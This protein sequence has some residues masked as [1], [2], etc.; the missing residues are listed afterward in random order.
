MAVNPLFT[1]I[2]PTA[3]RADL[4]R[5]AI[6][7]VMKQHC[8]DWEICIVDDGSTDHT[9]EVVKNFTDP[10]IHYSYQQHQER[11]V[12]RN[13]GIEMAKGQ[14]LCFLDDD[15]YF[16]PEHLELLR[17]SIQKEAYPV[18]IFRT[19]ML[20]EREGQFS[21]TPNFNPAQSPNP[22]LFFLKN[23]AGI[24]TLCFHQKIIQTYSFDPRWF[25]FQDTHLLIR[26]L[27][28]FP[29][30]QLDTYTCVYVRYENMGSISVF[31]SEKAEARTAN[32]VSAIRD[33]FQQGGQE[34]QTLVPP[35]LEDYLV[36]QKYLDHAKGALH[37]NRTALSWRYFQQSLGE[38]KKAWLLVPYSK[39]LLRWSIAFLKN[40]L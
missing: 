2:I 14:Y 34:L 29:F 1:I 40:L 33:L 5:R 31:K 11:S 9:Q 17:Q 32:N 28:D 23:M 21:K 6:E 36:C 12:A 39:Y 3:N 16:F 37:V 26:A 19:G 10:R 22:I 38:N 15:D 27:L 8:T 35:H 7:S 20:I 30:Y 25:H 24:H 18:A 4:L 13:K